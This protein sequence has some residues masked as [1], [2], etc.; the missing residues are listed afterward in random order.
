MN[1]LAQTR[2]LEVGIAYVSDRIDC[3]PSGGTIAIKA[4]LGELQYEC[5]GRGDASLATVF[6]NDHLLSKHG[7]IGQLAASAARTALGVAALALAKT[8]VAGVDC[9]SRYFLAWSRRLRASYRLLGQRRVSGA[10]VQRSISPISFMVSALLP[11]RRRSAACTAQGSSSIASGSY[12]SRLLL[13]AA[14]PRRHMAASAFL[15]SGEILLVTDGI[16]CGV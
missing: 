8:R 13:G 14:M 12:S 11:R 5:L 3:R 1:D 4:A 16:V 2:T 10:R 15:G 6:P 9:G 7:L